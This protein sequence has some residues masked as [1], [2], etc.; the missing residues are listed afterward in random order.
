MSN[1]DSNPFADPEANNPFAVSE[2]QHC[3]H[4]HH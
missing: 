3:C 4:E 2:K 1:F